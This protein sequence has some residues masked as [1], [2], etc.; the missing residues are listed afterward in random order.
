[1]FSSLTFK[2]TT[3][4][5][6]SMAVIHHLLGYI[7]NDAIS[8]VIGAVAALTVS[9]LFVR[10]YVSRPLEELTKSMRLLEQ[11]NSN[12]KLHINGSSQMRVLSESFNLMVDRVIILLDSTAQQIFEIAQSQERSQHNAELEKVNAELEKS[13][14]E[15]RLL[16]VKQ[17]QTFMSAINALVSTIEA[18]DNY[19]HGHSE[20]VTTYSMAL[21]SKIALPA[22]R[23]KILEQAAILHDIGKIGIDRAI[24]HKPGKLTDHEY[25]TM[26]KHPAIGLNILKNIDFLPAVRECVGKHHERFDG[27][28]Y[29]DGVCGGEL[30][31]EA[32]IM[33]IADTFDAM[34]SHRSYRKGLLVEV[35]I[36]E[37]SAHA[38]SQFDPELVGHFIAMLRDGELTP[39]AEKV[40]FDQRVQTVDT[41]PKQQIYTPITALV[42][43]NDPISSLM[44]RDFLRRMMHEVDEALTAEAAI[45]LFSENRYDLVLL[46]TELPDYDGYTLARGM[47]QIEEQLGV[48]YN[49]RTVI[50][51]LVSTNEESADGQVI[52]SGM[53]LSIR[54]PFT[55]AVMEDILELASQLAERNSQ[56]LYASS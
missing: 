19:T 38:G 47:R 24:L 22:D 52:A 14:A 43:E 42:V 44:V 13:L 50:C 46:D 10:H 26:K 5:T 34:T 6:I 53:N 2:L 30:P 37:L 55:A 17:E 25:D 51:A 27:K 4:L 3:I 49:N 35:A 9:A 31:I 23:R 12:A 1:V 28:G 41:L 8:V 16:N 40:F 20:R 15:V 11:G 56:D 29:P 21:A 48:E 39:L 32:R 45:S 33:S 54:K 18:S 7:G 36:G